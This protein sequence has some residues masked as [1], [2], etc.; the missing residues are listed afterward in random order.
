MRVKPIIIDDPPGKPLSKKQREAL[1]KWFRKH[2][3]VVRC[4]GV[5]I[6]KARA[7]VA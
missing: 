5:A 3:T 4:E 2:Y 6:V 7:E 1:V